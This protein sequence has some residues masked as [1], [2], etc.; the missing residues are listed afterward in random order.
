[1][2][3]LEQTLF[4]AVGARERALFMTEEL[5]LEQ[6]LGQCCAVDGDE[7]TASRGQLVERAG[8]EFLAGATL[9]GD[10]HGRCGSRGAAHE[11]VD[12]L[13]DATGTDEAGQGEGP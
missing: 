9:A 7:A 2:C 13:D 8:D 10:E 12:V 5:G 4:V 6:V 1:V 11:V 3:G